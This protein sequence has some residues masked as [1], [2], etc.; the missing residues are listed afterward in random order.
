MAAPT[1]ARRLRHLQSSDPSNRTCV[2]CVQKNPQWASVSYGVFMCLECS[3]RHR[4]L[5][6]HVSFVRS[7]TMDSW[8][9]IQIKKMESGGNDNL[10]SFLSKRG[11]PKDTDIAEKY[12]SAAAA[13]YRDRIKA[14]A[15]GRPWSDPPAVQESRSKRPPVA[16][17]AAVGRGGVYTRKEL[18]ESAAG[19]EGFFARKMAENQMRP[20]GLPPAQGGKYVGFGSASAGTGNGN[21]SGRRNVGPGGQGDV[22]SVV[23]Q[24]IVYLVWM[25]RFNFL[26]CC[27][28][29]VISF[30]PLFIYLFGIW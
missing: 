29:A 16:A 2:D 4:G 14:L 1:A 8:S 15:E 21:G 6:V 25:H 17:A 22:M 11:I 12:N 10:N 23:S 26:G 13:A 7:V 18:E 20:E 9:E 5:G 3:G 30:F 24:V 19:K 27:C 28:C